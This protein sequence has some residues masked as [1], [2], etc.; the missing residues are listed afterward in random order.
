MNPTTH[1]APQGAVPAHRLLPLDTLPLQTREPADATYLA[2]KPRPPIWSE[3]S[4]KVWDFF[5]HIPLE[6]RDPVRFRRAFVDDYEPN[7]STLLP[8]ALADELYR[9]TRWHPTPPAA[10]FLDAVLAE[11]VADFSASSAKLE[12]CRFEREEAVKL[13]KLEADKQK[14]AA[15]RSPHV[16]LLVNHRNAV[17]QMARLTPRHGLDVR[18]VKALHRS[19]MAG[20]LTTRKLGRT[21]V[22]SAEITGT[23]YQPSDDPALLKEM[24]AQIVAKA[25]AT[26]NPIEAAF[27][28]WIQ[29][30]YL[31]GFTDGNKRTGRLCANVPLMLGN[32]SPLS[33]DEVQHEHYIVAML[34]VYERNDVSV[35]AD[36]FEWLYRRS[37]RK[38]L[39]ML[40]A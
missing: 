7:R 20:D 6:Y 9:A 33:F 10:T 5:T 16:R 1:T 32:C 21:R 2:S 4:R 22:K 36:L 26:T 19:L 13:F 29:I 15:S 25:A 24:L 35:A 37:M 38:Y 17:E 12:G 18:L 40:S 27:F 28:L 23:A 30:A 8:R 14:L 11:F 31:Q 39:A 3:Q 34:G